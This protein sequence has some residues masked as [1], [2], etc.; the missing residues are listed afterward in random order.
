[1]LLSA[2]RAYILAP[3]VGDSVKYGCLQYRSEIL[4]S[5]FFVRSMPDFFSGSLDLLLANQNVKFALNSMTQSCR[6]ESVFYNP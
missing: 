5:M 6:N 1:M 2:S 3:M 4:Y